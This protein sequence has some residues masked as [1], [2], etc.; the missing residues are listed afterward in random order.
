MVAQPG[1]A[2]QLRGGN[3]AE[4]GDAFRAAL[5][6][7]ELAAY[8]RRRWEPASEYRLWLTEEN[9]PQL[10]EGQALTLYRASNSR[11]TAQFQA[12]PIEE[13]RDSLDFLLYDTIKLEGR[14]D[15]SMGEEGAYKLAGAG[16][17]FVS[18]LL[19]LREPTLFGV[20]NGNAERALRLV[21]LD[22]GT[23][24]RGLWGLRYIDLLDALHGVLRRFGL[25][26]FAE[27][28]QMAYW[29]TR[30]ERKPG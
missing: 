3:P 15:E 22:P 2:Q 27:V 25:A 20:W 13:I 11:R 1:N 29:L 18:Y 19:C 30:P 8:N 26:D 10:T 21:G 4:L 17:E 9:L 24:R 7:G 28:D 23:L 16:K 14:L 6:G 5:A 12:N